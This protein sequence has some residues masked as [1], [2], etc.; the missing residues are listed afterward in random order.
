MKSYRLIQ[1]QYGRWDAYEKDSNTKVPKAQN[2]T[3]GTVMGILLKN[4]VAINVELIPQ[5][6]DHTLVTTF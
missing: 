1:N 4:K 3:L 6:G 2:H 5:S